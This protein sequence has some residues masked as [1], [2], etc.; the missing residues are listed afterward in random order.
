MKV[1]ARLGVGFG[2]ITMLM[3][4]VGL[5]A[6]QRLAAV[7][8][9]WQ[10]F[11]KITLVKKNAVM[12]G[13]INLGNGVHHF[14]NYILRGGDYNVKFMQDM[15]A[16]DKIE[17]IYHATG[18]V[19]AEEERLLAVIKDGTRSY[20]EG[21]S[22]LVDLKS[23]QT[24]ITELDNA[25]K[26]ADKALAEAL[27][28]FFQ[29]TESNVQAAT[30][31]FSGLVSMTQRML[32]A[33]GVLAIILSTVLAFSIART[34]LKQLGGEPDEAATAL[35]KIAGGDLSTDLI[36]KPGDNSSLLYS[37]KTMHDSL[38]S[39]IAEI[40]G[41][42]E[43]AVQGDF[44][45]AM[46]MNGKAGYTQTLSELLNRLNSTNTIADNL[47]KD[48]IRVA[49]A[50]AQGD[51]SQKIG[52][53]YSGV[54][55]QVKVGV[56][57]TVDSLIGIVG[58]IQGLVEAANRGDFSKKIDVDGK[59]GYSK[60][61]SELLNQL[62]NV[63]ETG[64]NDVVRVANALAKGDL[65]QTIDRD[66]PGSFGAMKTGVNGSVENLKALIGEIK[67][68]TDTLST[69]AKEIAAGNNDLSHRT[70]EQ[71][72]SL[73]QTAASM[74][75]LTSTVQQN[76]ANASHA[77]QL[78]VGATDI[79]GKGVAVVERVV[80]TMEDIN[81]SS[82]KIVDIISVIDGIAFQT[83]ILALNAAVEAARAG[84][85]GRG[86]AVVAG[87]VRN[88]AQRAA[89]AAGEIKNL[90]GD[91][92]EKVGDGTKL[93]AQAGLTMEE[94]VSAIRGVTAIMSEIRGASIEQT[95]GIEQVNQAIGQMD[96]VTQQN[97]ALVEEAAAAA[98]SLE[99]QAQSLSVSV[100]RFTVDSG[101]QG[102]QAPVRVTQAVSKRSIP[103]RAKPQLQL[104]GSDE[105]EEF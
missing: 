63:T 16:L 9:R 10:D 94:I 81:E 58:E 73:E 83:N 45:K 84:E 53:D 91:S 87:E 42:V 97:A 77:N 34:L 99:E 20:R 96:E 40:Q 98:E 43:A 35:N 93:V 79:A 82:R 102:F 104:A 75:E 59:A 22:K 105:W 48:T 49:G 28:Q 15:D 18:S 30:G 47:F 57:T 24:G 52:R 92:V 67:V 86:F 2:V 74:E 78:A 38:R 72:A 5:I 27:A 6:W 65:T 51:L 101:A 50:L 11:E 90:I 85:Q 36:L 1:G 41:V 32:G 26:G 60:T 76:T 68:S 44:S 95:S 56:N 12:N 61:L 33:A 19:S 70:E 8:S 100:G 4:V 7:E 80:T 46:D 103:V 54:Y 13:Y 69:V 31:D 64:I 17:Q 23:R 3:V 66:Y 88:L 37:M 39:I 14:K 89:A 29:L 25:V 71:A 21:M 55:N 62:S